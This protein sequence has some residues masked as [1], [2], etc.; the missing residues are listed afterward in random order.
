MGDCGIG[1]SALDP[2]KD[3]G[4]EPQG[5]LEAV[6]IER[7]ENRS[8]AV[9]SHADGDAPKT[10]ER[11]I[12]SVLFITSLCLVGTYLSDGLLSPRLGSTYLDDAPPI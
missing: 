6:H 3:G 7:R 8:A 5:G 4:Q 1:L 2:G 9:N 11:P 10:K 12:S